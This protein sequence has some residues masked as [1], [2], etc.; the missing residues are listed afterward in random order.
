MYGKKALHFSLIK[1][2]GWSSL[3]LNIPVVDSNG[4]GDSFF[5][6]F[7]CAFLNNKPLRECLSNM[8]QSAGAYAVTS[9][10]LVTDDLS[11]QF[12]EQKM[13]EVDLF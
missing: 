9:H 1:E 11:L 12:V 5:A 7:L 6:G 3:L 4:A 8:A 10:S 13:K 2:N